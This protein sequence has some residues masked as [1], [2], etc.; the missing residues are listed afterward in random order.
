MYVCMHVRMYVCMYVC[1][2]C[3]Y[4][5]SGFA[6]FRRPLMQLVVMVG[7]LMDSCG[8]SAEVFLEGLNRFDRLVNV[9]NQ[10]VKGNSE[11]AILEPTWAHW[12]PIGGHVGPCWGQ[13]GAK[14]GQLGPSWG[15]HKLT[16]VILEPTWAILGPT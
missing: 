10:T 7:G 16:W 8:G 11:A 4:V 6:C 9:Q 3:M 12:G 14:L 2:Y 15:Q 1:M 13:V 5:F